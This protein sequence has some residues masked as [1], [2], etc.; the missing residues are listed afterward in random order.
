MPSNTKEKMMNRLIMLLLVG[1]AFGSQVLY[2]AGQGDTASFW[3]RLRSKLESFTPQNR[4]TITNATGGVRG[5]PMATED[6]YWKGDASTRTLDS[7][8]L[9]AFKKAVAFIDLGDKKQ[10]QTAFSEFIRKYPNS[11]LRKDADQALALSQ[12]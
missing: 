3:E 4:V 7:V 1:L 6:M 5:A 8:E 12:P 2:A 11:S 9:E 10:A